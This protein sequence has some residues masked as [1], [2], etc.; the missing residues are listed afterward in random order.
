MRR[1]ALLLFLLLAVAHPAAAQV[2]VD[3][4]G[5]GLR[6][7]G[8]FAGPGASIGSDLQSAVDGAGI[9][10]YV[11]VFAEDTGEDPSL[12]AERISAGFGSGTFFVLTPDFIGVFSVDYDDAEVE[13]ALDAAWDDFGSSDA[14]GI[15]AFERAI[16]GEGGFPFGTVLLLVVVGGIVW[17]VWTKYLTFGTISSERRKEIQ[18]K[19]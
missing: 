16:T 9:P 17:V 8:T 14:E 11:A 19:L 1:F 15:E 12:T 18:R 6:T 3:E 7:E 2:D 5:A 4:V 10:I 13:S